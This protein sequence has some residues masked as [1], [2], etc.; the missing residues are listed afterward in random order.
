MDNVSE[1]LEQCALRGDMQLLSEVVQW[2]SWGELAVADG[3]AGWMYWHCIAAGVALP[4][5]IARMWGAEYRDYAG[6]NFV[7]LHQLREVLA[8]LAESGIEATVLPGAP[9]LALYPDPGCRPMDDIDLLVC[10]GEME[11]AGRVLAQLGYVC[12]RHHPDLFVGSGLVV[13]LHVDLFHTERVS[14]RRFTGSLDGDAVRARSVRRRVEGF[15]LR[16]PSAEDMALY[17]AVHALRHSY[18]RLNWFIDLQ[19]LIGREVDAEQLIERAR[20][21]AL[22]RPLLYALHFLQRYAELP[23]TLQRWVGEQQ[24]GTVEFWFMRRMWADRRRGELGDVLWSFSIGSNLR[25]LFF[26][27]QTLFPRPVVLMQVFPFLP[28]PLFPLAYVLR[29]V[30]LLLRGGRQLVG[31]VRKC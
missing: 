21:T 7:A 19:L 8:F 24:L 3:V 14:A 5:D 16:C 15:E 27:L 30:Q 29:L 13:D 2:N 17:G 1:R 4:E 31:M 11:E 28:A 23:G 20:A 9:L 12:P 10:A 6:R 26:V 22:E 25:R 18:R